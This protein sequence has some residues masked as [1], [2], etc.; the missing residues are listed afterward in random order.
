M[1]S[2]DAGDSYDAW[3]NG[4]Y[5]KKSSG[6]RKI[7]D[8]A[9]NAATK[10]S[11]NAA[12]TDVD[13]KDNG[14]ISVMNAYWKKKGLDEFTWGEQIID[15]AFK[16][17]AVGDI[18]FSKVGWDFRKETIGKGIVYL[19]VF[20]YVIWEMQDAINDC[21]AG[22]LSANAD[23][24]H[25]WDEAV[26]FYTGSLEG[27]TQGGDVGLTG[28][29]GAG[30]LQFTVAEKRCKNFGTCTADFDMN[31]YDGYSE[32]N[33]K[34]MALFSAGRDKILSAVDLTSSDKCG[35]V[36]ETMNEISGLMLVP[37]IQGV[38]RY[39][40]KTAQ[41]TASA[42]EAGELFAFASAALPFI[43]AVDPTAAEKLYNRAWKQDFTTE[44]DFKTIKYAVEGTYS[45][46]GVGAG[47]GKVTCSA[48][49]ELVDSGVVQSTA[50]VDAS[51]IPVHIA[52]YEPASDVIQHSRIDLD[53]D[54]IINDL[55][56]K[57][58]QKVNDCAGNYCNYEGTTM[59][60]DAGDSYDAW[61]NGKY[62]KKSSG[63]RKIRDLAKNAATKSSG[64]SAATDVDYKDNGFISVMNAYW[65]KKRLDEF[66]WGEQIIDAAFK[67]TAIGDID[68]S[69]VGWDFRKETIG[70]GIVYL[71]VFPYVI[72]EMQDAINDCKAGKLSANA[73]S[74]HA[75]DEAVAF[76]T[77]SLEGTIQGGSATDGLSG[78]VG[79]GEL[80][81]TVAEKRCINFG[82]CTAG[83]SA[84]NI[85]YSQ[86][87][88]DILKLFTRGRDE[89]LLA[90]SKG[91]S[92][93]YAITETMN[94][95]SGLMLVPFIQGVQRYLYKTS[96]ALK[97]K[98][99]GELF[100]FASAAL[101][102]IDAVD[103][104]AAEMLYNRAWKQDFTTESDFKTIKYAVEGT[105]S[106]LGVGA[107]Q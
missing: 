7:R 102:F 61:T 11:G 16:G 56:A 38:Q 107:G 51:V 106:H 3:T 84:K 33:R 104:T 95:I 83:G 91:E 86:A 97:A 100:A 31:P 96:V 23:S 54:S 98:E 81:F 40:Y 79:A 47:Q 64:N 87:N 44:S 39:L 25:A 59:S 103:P 26:A 10:S 28:G 70:K 88:F 77:G 21:K 14:F 5:S 12:A 66:T 101:P 62:S 46:L 74:V 80:Q 73:D 6:I 92:A 13:Y 29:Y 17:T 67:G 32:L 78:G 60:G 20:P 57:N 4:K 93:C 35:P 45:H 75:W 105:Y 94:E 52:G 58:S 90:V 85:G 50:C 76:Y 30:E 42:K 49:G 43:D 8:F 99:A 1:G 53:V 48:V 72:W 24:V 2:G 18:D 69:K 9:K 55:P 34:V 41:G 71:N 27:T 82:T 68:F 19:S 36:I 65:K 63:I 22:K 37:F 89:I 15:A